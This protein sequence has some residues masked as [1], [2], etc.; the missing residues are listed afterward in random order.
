MLTPFAEIRTELPSDRF[1][2]I[3]G[4]DIYV[5]QCG[6]GPAVLL[7][8]GFAAS[9]Y[10]FR[11]I[12]PRLEKNYRVISI[13]LNG[14]G[15][16]E[17]PTNPMAY[18]AVAQVKTLFQVMDA[19]GVGEFSVVGHSYGAV[20]GLLSASRAPERIRRLA[21]ISPPSDFK[22]TPWLLGSTLGRLGAYVMFRGLLS[23]P[24]RF[25]KVLSNAFHKKDIVTLRMSE[26]Y[27]R[28]LLIEGLYP[29]FMGLC[30]AMRDDSVEFDR[31]AIRV[32]ALVL[33][34]AHDA[35]ADPAT[36]RRL[37]D[38]LPDARFEL[39]H[40]SGHSSPEEEPEAV[41]ELLRGFL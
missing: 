29:A 30:R 37:A 20:V 19:L 5:E 36:A 12:I 14:F 38:N 4:Q 39:L 28:R 6:S 9:S 23:R 17:R 3:E 27:R 13:D 24:E 32:P 2:S 41:A 15:F 33:A 1:L 11:D 7:L 8:H 31:S 16:T 40:D 21:L 34:G 18:R 25:Q 10:S 22:K 26:E 35:V